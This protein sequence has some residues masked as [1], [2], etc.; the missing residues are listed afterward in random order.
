[1][2]EKSSHGT[3]LQIPLGAVNALL[4]LKNAV[5]QNNDDL[6]TQISRLTEH[7]DVIK[8]AKNQNPDSADLTK[9]FA[10]KLQAKLKELGEMSNKGRLANILNNEEM[11]LQI[12]HIIEGVDDAWKK[13]QV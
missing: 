5:L 9:D 6:N 7:L 2:A 1:M 11:K 3:V 8:D 12:N 10:R 4:D 13:L